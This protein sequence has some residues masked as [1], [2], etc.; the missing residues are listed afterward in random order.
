MARLTRREQIDETSVGVYHCINRCVRQ[1]FLCG[2]DP[3][4]GNNYD[5]RK[6]WIQQRLEFLAGEFAVDVIGFS[7]L[8]NHFHLIL[9]NRPDVVDQWTDS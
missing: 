7:V 2:D 9:R 8:S 3:V 5:H 4:S 6:N 1:A